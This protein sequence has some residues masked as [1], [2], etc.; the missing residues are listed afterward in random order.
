MQ[1]LHRGRDAGEHLVVAQRGLSEFQADQRDKAGEAGRDAAQAEDLDDNSI[2]IDAGCAGR[3]LVVADGVNRASECGVIQNDA[4]DEEERKGDP[5]NQ[6]DAQ[7]AGHRPVAHPLSLYARRAAVVEQNRDALDDGARRVGDDERRDAQFD[8]Q[9]T[10]DESI[11]DGDGDGNYHVLDFYL[12]RKDYG[13]IACSLLVPL[14]F[15]FLF[16]IIMFLVVLSMHVKY[17]WAIQEA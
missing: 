4:A 13:Y 16:F 9:E 14:E 8:V 2:H 5:R 3:G 10:G 17:L 11:G 6:R 12:W 1:L 7:K 15:L